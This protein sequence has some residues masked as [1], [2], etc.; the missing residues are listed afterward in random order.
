MKHFNFRRFQNTY[1][2]IIIE[3]NSCKH[4]QEQLQILLQMLDVAAT[5]WFSWDSQRLELWVVT[6]PCPPR[7]QIEWGFPLILP[8]PG[9]WRNGGYQCVIQQHLPSPKWYFSRRCLCRPSLIAHSHWYTYLMLQRE[10][11]PP[12]SSHSFLAVWEWLGFK[13]NDCQKFIDFGRI[14]SC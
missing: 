6:S 7:N 1:T 9:C 13:A 12:P 14:T 5:N 11:K 2:V 10:K 8:F 3:T 4:N